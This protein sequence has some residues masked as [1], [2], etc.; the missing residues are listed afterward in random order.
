MICQEWQ[1]WYIL[2]SIVI[3]I[4]RGHKKTQKSETEANGVEKMDYMGQNKAERLVGMFGFRIPIIMRQ[5][6]LT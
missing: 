4:E 3:T 5:K 2:K 6:T 1:E